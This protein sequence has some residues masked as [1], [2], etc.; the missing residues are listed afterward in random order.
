MGA[1]GS[2]GY[3]ATYLRRGGRNVGMKASR[4]VYIATHGDLPADV[5]V[6]HSCDNPPCCNPAHLR[7]GSHLE[8]MADRHRAGR[9]GRRRKAA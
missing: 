8:N 4:A 3:G 2:G 7:P 9:Y 6:L 5:H 1:I